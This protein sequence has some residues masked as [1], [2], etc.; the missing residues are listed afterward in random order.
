MEALEADAPQPTQQDRPLLLIAFVGYVSWLFTE[1]WIPKEGIGAQLFYA[2]VGGGLG[3]GTLLV[4]FPRGTTVLLQNLGLL[5]PYGCLLA[6]LTALQVVP[7]RM[8]EF[9]LGAPLDFFQ[10]GFA[11]V[12]LALAMYWVTTVYIAWQT[13]A[14]VDAVTDGRTAL[15]AGLRR[16]V[17]LWPRTLA[18]VFVAYFVLMLP[19]ML[20]MLLSPPIPLLL[21]ATLA[22]GLIWSFWTLAWLPLALDRSRPLVDSLRAGIQESRALP[23][24]I[25]LRLAAWAAALGFVTYHS[26]RSG[27]ST[28]TSFR[29]NVKWLGGYPEET[30]WLKPFAADGSELVWFARPLML[31]FLLLAIA[32][33]CEVVQA[34]QRRAEDATAA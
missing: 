2:V 33:K 8:A 34:I 14:I 30:E 20:G 26:L 1:T 5:A 15:R 22:W 9:H 6:A 32:V 3:L 21:L 27:S 12:A 18:V 29:V 13:L 16:A 10:Q 24:T 25:K 31:L 7:V 17:T 23:A 4:A 11:A 19:L 28:T